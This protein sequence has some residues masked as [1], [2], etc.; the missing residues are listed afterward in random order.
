MHFEVSKLSSYAEFRLHL[1]LVHKDTDIEEL[2][3]AGFDKQQILVLPKTLQRRHKLK[4]KVAKKFIEQYERWSFVS[5]SDT[6][7]SHC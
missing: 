1:N 3:R 4:I 6:Y 7:E 5:E 2:T